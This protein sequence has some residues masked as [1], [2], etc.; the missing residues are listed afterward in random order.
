MYFSLSSVNPDLDPE[1]FILYS[2]PLLWHAPGFDPVH[3]IPGEKP[4]C[5]DL[6]VTDQPS[7]IDLIVTDQP[8]CI[9]LI[10]TDQPSCIDLIVT[11]QPSCIDLIVTDQPNIVLDNG[12]RILRSFL[13]PDNLL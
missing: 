8:S 9:D 12:T 11:D 7:C 1:Q 6:I 13:S 4:S 5:I 10:V 3:I 2:T